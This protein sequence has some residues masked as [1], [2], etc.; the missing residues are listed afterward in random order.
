MRRL[1]LLFFA[2]IQRAAK[3]DIALEQKLGNKVEQHIEDGD[4]IFIPTDGY[5]PV[6][7]P[8]RQRGKEQIVYKYLCHSGGYIGSG[9]EGE[10]TVEGKV[11]YDRQHQRDQVA[12]PI[13]PIGHFIEQSK[14]AHLDDAGTNRE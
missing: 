8:G 5:Q 13:R 10:L 1:F 6:A 3:Y 9:L 12:W 4:D 14:A 7:Q 11:P 2:G